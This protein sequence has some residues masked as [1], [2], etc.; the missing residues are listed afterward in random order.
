MS[1]PLDD[2]QR[3]KDTKRV[4]PEEEPETVSK[5]ELTDLMRQVEGDWPDQTFKMPKPALSWTFKRDLQWEAG[6]LLRLPASA[7]DAGQAVW[8]IAL[9]CLDLPDKIID[10][11]VRGD[12]VI[13]RSDSDAKPDLDL[14]TLSA[15]DYGISRRHALL[16]PT[17]EKLQLTDLGSTNGTRR[18]GSLLKPKE[19]QTLKDKDIVTFG[20]LQFQVRVMGRIS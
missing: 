9:V 19:P 11:E 15:T 8:R 12:V 3:G 5:D 2:P 7:T 16:H 13:G 6:E 4:S 10:M 17:G 20:R 18:N 14:A 1:K